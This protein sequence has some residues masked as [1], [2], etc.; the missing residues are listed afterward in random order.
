MILVN[1]P[2]NKTA[3]QMGIV[4]N[5]GNRGMQSIIQKA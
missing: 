1:A 5:T 4:Q 3:C 2:F